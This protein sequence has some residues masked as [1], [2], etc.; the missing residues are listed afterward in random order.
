MTKDDAQQA[1]RKLGLRN[2]FVPQTSP[3]ARARVV[4]P[5]LEYYCMTPVHEFP[6]A[7]AT[8]AEAAFINEAGEGAAARYGGCI[9]G[10]AVGRGYQLYFH[11]GRDSL[12]DFARGY[13]EWC[14]EH[15]TPHVLHH[16]R[17]P[18]QHESIVYAIAAAFEGRGVRASDVRI[19][20]YGCID[21]HRFIHSP[22]DPVHGTRN[23]IRIRYL[24]QRDLMR[25]LTSDY[26]LDLCSLLAIQAERIG[27]QV[28]D[29]RYLPSGDAFPT[30][31][32]PD[33]EMRQ[34]RSLGVF[35]REA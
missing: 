3:V 15:E 35:I 33:P 10:V 29:L 24:E 23:R 9:K 13:D 19:N 30:T 1:L 28:G 32:H 31:G 11:A 4:S 17:G 34:L 26:G 25:A 5:N 27:M 18:R 20:G 8:D 6:R 16:A 2:V 14:A 12:M 7:Q 22:E 21:P